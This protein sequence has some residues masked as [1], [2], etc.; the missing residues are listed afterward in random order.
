MYYHSTGKRIRKHHCIP[1]E[2]SS[3][4]RSQSQELIPGVTLN[5]DYEANNFPNAEIHSEST[6][7]NNTMHESLPRSEML[8]ESPLAAQCIVPVEAKR[9][10]GYPGSN[11]TR[12]V[13]V[14]HAYS[15]G[16]KHNT[17]PFPIANISD[18]LNTEQDVAKHGTQINT[19]D[20][21]FEAT[22]ICRQPAQTVKANTTQEAATRN[23]PMHVTKP[24]FPSHKMYA[25]KYPCATDV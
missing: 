16:S 15:D 7:T 12:N 4:P 24:S 11:V 5:P 6:Y 3:M 17:F 1:R 20:E 8:Q 13:D 2:E 23:V 21:C 22:A 9:N 18:D 25:E 19:F 14:L 10:E